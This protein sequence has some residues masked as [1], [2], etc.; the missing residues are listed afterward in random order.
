[1]WTRPSMPSPTWTKAPKGTSFVTRPETSSPTR[2]PEAN[3]CQAPCRGAGTHALEAD[4][5]NQAALDAFDDRALHDAVGLLDLFDRAPGPLVLGPLLGQDQPA[6]LV[7]LLENEGLD[8]VA[9]G[10]DLVGVDVVADG[11]LAVGDDPFR[12]VADVEEHL[13]LV[14]L[15][16]GAGDDV[17]LVELDDGARDGVGERHAAEVVAHDLHGLV[18]ALGVGAAEAGTGGRGRLGLGRRGGFGSGG[19]RSRRRRR[20]PCAFRGSRSSRGAALR[21]GDLG[22][23]GGARALL[24]KRRLRTPCRTLNPEA[25]GALGAATGVA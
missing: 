16:D 18:L 7:P 24:L 2:W 15:D 13:V 22:G 20:L 9:G 12:L 17:A 25:M 21:G 11:Q 1:M 23:G 5:E 19:G 8:H 10:D 14:D 3:C 4:V 6:L